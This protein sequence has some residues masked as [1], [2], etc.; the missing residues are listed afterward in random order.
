MGNT[1]AGHG[2]GIAG[3][4]IADDAQDGTSV[5]YPRGS[6]DDSPGSAI[7]C[8][9]REIDITGTVI[10]ARGKDAV[11]ERVL[12]GIAI[13]PI[14]IAGI[15]KIYSSLLKRLWNSFDKLFLFLFRAEKG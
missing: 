14:A 5:V 6:D 13:T 15:G 1:G 3:G 4:T 7:E 10:S 11:F 2:A 9:I 8:T 12:T